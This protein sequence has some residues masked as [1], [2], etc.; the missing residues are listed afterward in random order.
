MLDS[1]TLM[2][3]VTDN[4]QEDEEPRQAVQEGQ[5]S[6]VE[7]S[8]YFLRKPAFTQIPFLL[9]ELRIAIGF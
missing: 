1:R 7:Y 4:F 9:S 5:M 6:D 8:C 3:T 2:S